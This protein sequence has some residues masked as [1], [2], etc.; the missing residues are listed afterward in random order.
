MT[1][2]APNAIALRAQGLLKRIGL[3]L[4]LDAEK[5]ER[6]GIRPGPA[7]DGSESR[8]AIKF[9]GVDG[10]LSLVLHQHNDQRDHP[11]E[12]D[13]RDNRQQQELE[14]T[15]TPTVTHVK[16]FHRELR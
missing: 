14:A 2:L 16:F 5:S 13:D 10:S 11:G 3:E 7:A 4:S 6:R 1:G 9:D 8:S 12:C 15:V